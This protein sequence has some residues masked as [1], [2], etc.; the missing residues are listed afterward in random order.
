[1]A[2]GECKFYRKWFNDGR[3]HIACGASRLNVENS[4]SLVET[5]NS[6]RSFNLNTIQATVANVQ[7]CLKKMSIEVLGTPKTP[8]YSYGLDDG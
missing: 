4:S 1:M 8:A 3:T 5:N 7:F 6:F 2:T